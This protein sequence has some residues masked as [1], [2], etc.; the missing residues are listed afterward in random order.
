MRSKKTLHHVVVMMLLI[1]SYAFSQN[2]KYKSVVDGFLILPE[3][4]NL[5]TLCK[6]SFKKY[7]SSENFYAAAD[8]FYAIGYSNDAKLAYVEYNN[9]NNSAGIAYMSVIVQDLTTDKILW[10]HVLQTGENPLEEINYLRSFWASDNE[11]ILKKLMGFGIDLDAPLTL[12]T[13]VIKHRSDLLSYSSQNT[14]KMGTFY[15][16]IK[17]IASS[18]IFIKSKKHGTKIVSTN[19]YKSSHILDRKP[20]GYLSLGKD[21]KR[22]A[23]IVANIFAGGH[24]PYTIN[25][26]IVGVNLEK[27]F[28]R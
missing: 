27:G 17:V 4:I 8:S 20:I 12:K 16:H 19:N 11:L 14:Q 15:S 25:Y 24:E 3:K 26:S 13:G 28:K 10:K 7:F 1:C 23:L 9:Q 21:S 6:H 22:V 18:N 5:I 2:Y